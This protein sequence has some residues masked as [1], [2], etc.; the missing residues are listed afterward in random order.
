[1]PMG[2]NI[3]KV[4]PYRLLSAIPYHRYRRQDDRTSVIGLPV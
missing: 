1:V 4:P 2:V 3:R